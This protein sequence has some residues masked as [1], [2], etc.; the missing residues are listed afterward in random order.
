[1]QCLFLYRDSSGRLPTAQDLLRCGFKVSE[2]ALRT[3][4]V[5]DP[6]TLQVQA[7]ANQERKFPVAAE[8][9]ASYGDSQ[10]AGAGELPAWP[11]RDGS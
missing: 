2:A 5:L 7:S 10:Q 11:S 4:A 9:M 6:R 8:T 3:A 1:M